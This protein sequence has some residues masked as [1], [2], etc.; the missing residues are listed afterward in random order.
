MAWPPWP[1]TNEKG[2]ASYVLPGTAEWLRLEVS[3]DDL[4]ARGQHRELLEAIYAALLKRDIR[5]AREPF[6]PTLEQ[7]LIRDP[8]A[9][10]QGAGDATCL[11]LALL[12][13]GLC[14]GN[15]LLPL[16]V[17]LD[18]HALVAV[19]LVRGRRDAGLPG[20]RDPDQD[21]PWVAEGLLKSG[22]ALRE[23]VDRGDYLLIECT[24]FARSDT[25]PPTG[26]EG[27][28]R[29]GGQM[30]FQRAVEAGREQLGP[31]GRAFVFAIDAAMLQ[32]VLKI[33]PHAKQIEL[34]PEQL[35][36]ALRAA[37]EAQQAVVKDLSRQ[38]NTTEEAVRGFFKILSHSDVPLEKLPQ[39]L[40]EIAQR[41]RDML[42]RLSALEPDDPLTKAKIDEARRLLIHA[43]SADAYD[44]AD[45][46]LAEAEGWDMQG[47]RE[48]EALEKDAR[49][50]VQRKRRSAAATR[51]ERGELSLTRLD[52]CFASIP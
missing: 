37:G 43:D 13:A 52:G 42:Q 39:T 2:L 48:A 40:T 36:A 33:Q 35:Q 23:L 15:E 18:G 10:L 41:H 5:Y 9:V 25:I 26:P 1:K 17:V 30:T 31:G 3:R 20:R 6:D 47:I 12:F 51:A 44:R 38:L 11:D 34:T 8:E 28:G 49:E 21:G 50:A 14:L 19:S 46:L 24:G 32:D 16:V 27:K 22:D 29:V 4:L 7:Q 45:V